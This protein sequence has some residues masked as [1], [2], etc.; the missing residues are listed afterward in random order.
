M[1]KIQDDVQDGGPA[2]TG[3]HM[4]AIMIAFF[5]VI[6]AVNLTMATFAISSWTGA[7]A[8]DTFSAS[9]HFN[10][11]AGQAKQQ[12]KLGWTS[13][14]AIADGRVEYRLTDSLG[15]VVGA[16]QA[17]ANFRR[18][19]YESEDQTVALERQP[20][21]SFA[22]PVALRDGLWIVEVESDAG[23]DHPYRTTRR[24]V[25]RSGKID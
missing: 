18:P 25:L 9:Q 10:N 23:L 15:N 2:F 21:G 24:L 6:I 13:R 22:A 7:V 20:D 8:K 14:L 1:N 5:G 4:L 17:T 3:R 19:A 11:I 16:R 12:D